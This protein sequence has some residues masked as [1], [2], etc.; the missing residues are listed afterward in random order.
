[1]T[2]RQQWSVV[3]AIIIVLGGGLLVASRMLGDQL[4]P[5][6]VG[7][8]APEFHAA[9]VDSTPRTQ[10]L[11]DY[12]GQVVLLNIWG[13]FCV[14]C[15]DEMP[16]IEKL[17]QALGAQGLKVVAIS[18]DEPGFEQQIRDFAKQYSLTFQILYDPSGKIVNDYQTTG[19]PETFVIARDG[20][21]R[22]KVIGAS[23]WN[24]ATNRALIAQLL[25]EPGK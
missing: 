22:K 12:K 25:A 13:T 24:S 10:S 21:I 16:A 23:D 5:V 3:A 4:Y 1:V 9:T 6:S 17:H 14:P 20:V 2:A 15:R 18:M 11:A 8:K 19:V 7:S